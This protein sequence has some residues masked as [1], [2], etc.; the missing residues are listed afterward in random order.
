M[1]LPARLSRRHLLLTALAGAVP[2]R[3]AGAPLVVLID[4]SIEMPQAQF[5]DGR[6][7]DGLQ[8][9]L[10]L[11]IGQ[12]LGRAVRFRLVPRRSVAQILGAGREADLICNYLPGWL[13]GPL[14]WSRPYLDDADLLVTAARR[15]APAQLHDLAGQRIGTVSGFLYPETETALG[16]GFVRDDAPNLVTNLRKLASGRIDHAIVGRVTFDYLQRRGDVPLDLHPPLVIARLRTAC[17]LS[18]R[19]SLTLPQL[20]TALAALQADGSLARIVG[21]YR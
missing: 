7:V 3:A 21:K 14:R 9:D 11:A 19:S 2:A 5:R 10:G 20:D 1:N 6:A 17:A 15:P 18:P 12:R 8:Y 13:P 16:A 4:G